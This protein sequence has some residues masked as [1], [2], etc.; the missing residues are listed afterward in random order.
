MKEIPNSPDEL[1]K[2]VKKQEE[3]PEV[4]ISNLEDG[5]TQ[6]ISIDACAADL[7]LEQR[8]AI[9]IPQ[10]KKALTEIHDRAVDGGRHNDKD[11]SLCYLSIEQQAWFEFMYWDATL[12]AKGKWDQLNVMAIFKAQTDSMMATLTNMALA[13]LDPEDLADLVLRHGS[14][15]L[16]AVMRSGRRNAGLLDEIVDV[17]NDHRGECKDPDCSCKRHKGD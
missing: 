14:K 15:L 12:Q 1:L 10:L 8:A 16:D 2:Q 7:P 13:G 3:M 9:V 17:L 4:H 11:H 6:I 5:M